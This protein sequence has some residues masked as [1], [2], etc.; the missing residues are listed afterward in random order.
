[1]NQTLRSVKASITMKPLESDPERGARSVLLDRRFLTC[2]E[3]GWVHYVMTAE[4]KAASDRLLER[5]QLSATERHLYESAFRQCLRCESP[6]SAFAAAE[7]PDLARAAG[8]IVTPVFVE[9]EV[10]TH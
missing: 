1:M 6:A 8:H 4:E 9:G 10:G 2:Q 7:E 3:C 5:Y